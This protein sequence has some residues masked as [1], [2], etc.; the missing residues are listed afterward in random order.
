[1]AHPVRKTYKTFSPGHGR[2]N[3]G[4]TLSA[5]KKEIKSRDEHVPVYETDILGK[6]TARVIGHRTFANTV[7][8]TAIRRGFVA[9]GLLG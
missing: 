2:S 9:A 6:A 8:R 1:M 5:I 3:A 7:Q 4:I